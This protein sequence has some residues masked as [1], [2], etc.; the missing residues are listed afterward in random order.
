MDGFVALMTEGFHE[1]DWTDQEVGVAFGRGLPIIII[2]LGKDPYGFI[3]KFQALSCS[4]DK[5]AKEIVKILINQDRMLNSYI[6]AVQDCQSF[7]HGNV[8]A[9]ILPFID[10][11][12]QQQVSRLVS[13]FKENGQ[14]RDSYGFNG[15]KPN[16]YGM[17]LAFH[18]SRVTGQAY[19]L[20]YSGLEIEI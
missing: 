3:G 8:L 7:D 1:S 19:K 14:V 9:E 17:G 2:K 5:A 13:A 18:L 10:K 20:S 15:K 11:L 6:E 16:Y 12:S 4:W